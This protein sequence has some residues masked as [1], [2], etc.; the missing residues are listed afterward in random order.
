[1]SWLRNYSIRTRVFLMVSI[2]LALI[3]TVLVFFSMGTLQDST[4][5]VLTERSSMAH[6]IAGHIDNHIADIFTLLE[7]AAESKGFDLTDADPAPERRTLRE[8]FRAGIFSCQVFITDR[9]G[10]VLLTEPHSSKYA[11]E[12]R[13]GQ[14]YIAAALSTG[15]RRYQAILSALLVFLQ[16]LGLSSQSKIEKEQWWGCSAASR[17]PRH[18]LLP[19]LYTIFRR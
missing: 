19:A 3:L 4:D 12:D 9:R 6:L 1:M 11:G 15:G 14:P 10:R 8:L 18:R 5:R 2:S 13:S 16:G 17:I 7:R